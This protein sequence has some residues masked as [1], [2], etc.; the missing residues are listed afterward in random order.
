[1]A[2]YG[3][4]V[5]C[6]GELVVICG[7]CN[8]VYELVPKKVNVARFT[9]SEQCISR[10]SSSSVDTPQ[11]AVLPNVPV[12]SNYDLGMV[13]GSLTTKHPKE[14]EQV[15]PPTVQTD[16]EL[17]VPTKMDFLSSSV[18]NERGKDRPVPVSRESS[19]PTG[20][21]AVV[22]PEESVPRVDAKVAVT[23]DRSVSYEQGKKRVAPVSRDCTYSSGKLPIVVPLE[24]EESL[25]PKTSPKATEVDENREGGFKIAKYSFKIEKSLKILITGRSGSSKSVIINGILGH[26][27]ITEREGVHADIREERY[28]HQNLEGV[29]VQVL[30]TASLQTQGHRNPQYLEKLK[31]E[32]HDVDL[33]I[34]CI[35]ATTTRFLPGNPD[36]LAIDALINVFGPNCMDK[37]VF[38]LTYANVLAS[39]YSATYHDE[40][41]TAAAFKR[42]LSNW[43]DIFHKAVRH[44]GYQPKVVLT[45]HYKASQLPGIDD[46][47]LNLWLACVDAISR[48]KIP[49]MMVINQNR[50]VREE[51]LMHQEEDVSMKKLNVLKAKLTVLKENTKE[52]IA[53]FMD[54]MSD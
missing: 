26:K 25:P 40:A 34:Y 47:L 44:T 35:S 23:I 18:T 24:K 42:L 52:M 10:E 51:Q 4:C 39:T 31:S 36:L 19:W 29:S 6:K 13:S 45:G 16:A 2:S 41:S 37:T 15:P 38:A 54:L 43:E 49:T 12:S 46:W 32:Y 11:G 8:A 1:M 53:K 20:K 30:S 28:Y 17:E 50:L 14:C 27:I 22:A 48:D 21:L 5:L 3:N 7:C 9:G 33:I